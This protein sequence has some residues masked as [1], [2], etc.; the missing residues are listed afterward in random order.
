[1]QASTCSTRHGNNRQGYRS[2]TVCQPEHLI[3]EALPRAAAMPRRARLGLALGYFLL[4]IQGFDVAVVFRT[5]GV[6]SLCPIRFKL[7]S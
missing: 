5:Q 6:A 7:S 3:G 2:F 1:M 4:P